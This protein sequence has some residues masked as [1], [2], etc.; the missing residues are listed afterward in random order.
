MVGLALWARVRDNNRLPA[1]L[2]RVFPVALERAYAP[3]LAFHPARHRKRVYQYVA[4]YRFVWRW[5]FTIWL[6]GLVSYSANCTI[7]LTTAR[8]LT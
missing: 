5:F 6:S 1:A 4:L 8:L 3:D 2:A 7:H